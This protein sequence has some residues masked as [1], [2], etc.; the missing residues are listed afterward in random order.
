MQTNNTSSVK[1]RIQ[2]GQHLSQRKHLHHC[3]PVSIVKP[4]NVN[5]CA[6]ICESAAHLTNEDIAMNS[7][8]LFSPIVVA[9]VLGCLVSLILTPFVGL[10]VFVFVL[11]KLA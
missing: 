2:P 1:I 3:R 8:L 6:D 9:T 5:T 10:A 4:I 7:D 11:Y